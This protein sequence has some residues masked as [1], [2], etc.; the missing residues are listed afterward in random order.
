MT[1]ENLIFFNRKQTFSFIKQ[2]I[3][4]RKICDPSNMYMYVC[5]HL[6]VYICI[7]WVS[8]C[9]C[10]YHVCVCL[11]VCIYAFM[12][13]FKHV[14][15]TCIYINPFLENLLFTTNNLSDTAECSLSVTDLRQ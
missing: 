7:M 6:Y 11:C 12:C 8:I 4:T 13:L 15:C 14:M 2:M 9:V 5:M 1:I 3:Y 10:M